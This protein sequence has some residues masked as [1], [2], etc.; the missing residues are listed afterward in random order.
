MPPY[1][2][3]SHCRLHIISF[4]S[5][6]HKLSFSR[7]NNNNIRKDK[8]N[9]RGV[10]IRAL[11]HGNNIHNCNSRQRQELSSFFSV[12]CWRRWGCCLYSLQIGF[13]IFICFVKQFSFFWLFFP[14]ADA[15]KNLFEFMDVCKSRVV[16]SENIICCRCPHRAGST[17]Q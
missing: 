15:Q 16:D 5:L 1:C 8:H 13:P 14:R 11:L 3:T 7:Q 12:I 9:E 6:L 4:C 10:T 2:S 17:H